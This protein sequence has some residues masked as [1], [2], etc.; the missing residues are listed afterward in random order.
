M[1]HFF[2]DDLPRIGASGIKQFAKTWGGNSKMR[3]DECIACISAGLKDP[4]RVRAAIASLEP[5][6]RNALALI[7]RMGGTVHNTVLKTGL[8]AS[9]LHPRR[10]FSHKEEFVEH[11]FRRGLLLAAGSYGPE[12]VTGG[13]GNTT[14]YSDDRLLAHIGQPEC[15][16]LAIQPKQ[17]PGEVHSRRPPT[18]ALDIMGL[19][20][21]V[22][23]IGG[24]KLTLN[25]SVRASDESKF[26]KAMHWGKDSLDVDG[27][28]FP[29]P[30]QA[31]LESLRYSGIL[32]DMGDSLLN[33]AASPS[34]FARQPFGDQ[35]RVLMEGVIRTKNWWETPPES[36]R[37]TID[38][39]GKGRQ[40]GRLA[41]S[42]ALTALPVHLDAYFPI[43]K[44]EQ[45]LYN[46]IGEDFALDYPPSRP[47]FYYV[48]TP[49][50]QKK[51]LAVWQ[52]KT[53][54][55]WL[56][57]EYPWII[58]VF[59][60]WLYFLGLVALVMDG[61]KLVGFRLTDIGQQ[62]FHPELASP[63]DLEIA[64]PAQAQPAWVV[65]PNFDIIV[66]LDLVSAP[67]LAFLEH[68]AERTQ[69]HRNTAHYQLTRDS[70]YRGLESG[71]TLDELITTL[72]ADSQVELSQNVIV[73]LREWA[74]LRDRIILRKFAKVLEFPT[75]QAL[76]S[77]LS[78]G[79]QGKIIAERFLLLTSAQPVGDW[80]SINYATALPKN[81][82]AAEKGL[83]HWKRSPDDL[84][85]AATLNQWAQP[86]DADHWQL[87]QESVTTALKPG[88]K[89][90][91]LMNFLNLRLVFQPPLLDLALRSWA[92]VIYPVEL[93]TVIILKCPE[94]KVFQVI[95]SSPLML[96][97]FW[98]YIYP[99]LLFVI[100]ERIDSLRQQLQWLGLQVTEQLTVSRIFTPPSA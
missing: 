50:E 72:Q 60:T 42:L 73:E 8:L 89:I 90:T 77:G 63:A 65:Q 95:Q 10:T 19:L 35:I 100:P 68:I 2:D 46:R 64:S 29:N 84:F 94:E 27:F 67:Q 61:G 75:P 86:M 85:T 55:K 6:E 98:G 4:E 41:L 66:Y 3:K 99:S 58:G 1:P 53:R 92:H 37:L 44:F 33:L 20:Q 59:T 80:K 71:T 43:D 38:L 22:D 30:T 24:L 5:W 26:S 57:Q 87:T 62:T 16:P 51:E 93:E 15:L 56:K 18:V 11:L 54:T 69:S 31:W 97:Y 76:Q 25:G 78:S 39:D 88:R 83:I 13:Y 91:E 32:M 49:E 82:T 47:N 74:S 7:K 96:S 36:R 79:L 12:H 52:E 45:S 70:V 34:V 40:L 48:S 9:G 28:L 81:L 14:L 23:N 17:F 21:A